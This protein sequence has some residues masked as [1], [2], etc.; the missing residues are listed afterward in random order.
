MT[1]IFQLDRINVYFFTTCIQINYFIN[2]YIYARNIRQIIN[3]ILIF[4]IEANNKFHTLISKLENK[5][6]VEPV[7]FIHSYSCRTFVW[8]VV[9]MNGIHKNSIKT[10]IHVLRYYI[11]VRFPTFNTTSKY[12]LLFLTIQRII[13]C[14][15]YLSFYS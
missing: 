4:L 5:S 13:L 3:C 11:M 9:K 7:T 10:S 2:V 14:Y 8:K 1:Y 15:G 6:L 12:Y